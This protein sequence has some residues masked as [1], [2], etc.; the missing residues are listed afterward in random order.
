MELSGNE[1]DDGTRD[2]PSRRN[3][4]VPDASDSEFV[5]SDNEG[6]VDEYAR[7]TVHVGSGA[8]VIGGGH[9]RGWGPAVPTANLLRPHTCRSP[10]SREGTTTGLP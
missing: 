6:G 4:E 9:G 8:V 7:S 3:R 1:G 10:N 5:S 2:W